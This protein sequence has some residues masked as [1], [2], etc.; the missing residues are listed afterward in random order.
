MSEAVCENDNCLYK[1]ATFPQS[2]GAWDKEEDSVAFLVD[3]IEKSELFNVYREVPGQVMQPRFDVEQRN[4]KI[5]LIFSP[6]PKIYKAGWNDG[7]I[8]VECKRSGED[9]SKAF[10]QT[11][12]YSR[13]VWELPQNGFRFMCKYFFLWPFERNPG[14]VESVM[15]HSR[16]G[17]IH[18]KAYQ[19]NVVLKFMMSSTNVIK[20]TET[21]NVIEVKPI[22]CGNKCGSR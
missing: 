16:V 11:I 5:D 3:V 2:Y 20:W 4:V 22:V 7:P 8:G 17:I 18:H 21:G 12:D 13:S 14:F 15:S 19:N 1:K 6:K 10:V 9:L